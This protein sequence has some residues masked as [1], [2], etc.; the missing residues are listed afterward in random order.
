LRIGTLF[1]SNKL[2]SA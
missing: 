1:Y 2:L